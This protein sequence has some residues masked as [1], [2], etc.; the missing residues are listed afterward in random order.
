MKSHWRRNL[1]SA[2]QIVVG[3]EQT[4]TAGKGANRRFVQCFGDNYR[5]RAH[6][7]EK[8]ISKGASRGGLEANGARL[9]SFR[10]LARE[11]ALGFMWLLVSVTF[12]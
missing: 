10:A 7:Q 6:F 11:L 5:Q 3:C 2:T 1:N 9:A 8:P 12:L 4:I